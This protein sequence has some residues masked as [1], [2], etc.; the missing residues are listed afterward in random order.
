MRQEATNGVRFSLVLATVHRVTELERMIASLAAQTYRNF[1]LILVDQNSD[2]RLI[3]I[4]ERW[5]GDLQLIHLRT[6]PGLS[7]AR[8]LG[9]TFTRGELVGFPDDDCWYPEDCLMQVSEWFERFREY[10][11]LSTCSRDE[12][13][14]EVASRWPRRSCVIDRQS[15]LMTCTTFCLFVRR[16]SVLDAGGFDEEMGPGSRTPFQ[17]AEDL[18]LA[19][20]VIAGGKYGWFEKSIFVHHPRKDAASAP[21][22][23]AFHYGVGFGYLL[24]KHHYGVQVWLYHVLRAFAGVVRALFCSR[25]REARFYWN[26]ARGRIAGYWY[27][28]DPVRSKSRPSSGLSSARG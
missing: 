16:Q 9:L 14:G 6:G 27:K 22:E 7:S 28:A 20:R 19:L 25:F 12:T 1:E 3:P 8:N 15:V 23:R 5:K 2:D 18:D 17:A 24:R 26:S 10:S 11:L 21:V 13:G 4:V